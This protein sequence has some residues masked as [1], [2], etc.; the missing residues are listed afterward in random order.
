M[1]LPVVNKTRMDLNIRLQQ[2]RDHMGM[3]GSTNAQHMNKSSCS[4]SE[5]VC[6]ADKPGAS[7]HDPP[8][9]ALK[10]VPV[11]IARM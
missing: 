6:A 7:L 2:R 5:L 4:C 10:Q 1:F 3:A 11:L 9:V 8:E